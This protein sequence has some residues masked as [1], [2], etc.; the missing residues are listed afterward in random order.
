MPTI[1]DADVPRERAIELA[2]TLAGNGADF[3]SRRL[4]DSITYGREVISLDVDDREHLLAI[5]NLSADLDE[6]RNAL[7]RDTLVG[8][9]GVEPAT[10]GLK[11]PCSTS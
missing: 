4:L 5:D 6:L 8:R 11:V 1:A 3:T 10:L 9:A 2:S 7:I